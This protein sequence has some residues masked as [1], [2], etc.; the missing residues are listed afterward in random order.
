MLYLLILYNCLKFRLKHKLYDLYVGM[1]SYLKIASL[2]DY[3]NADIFEMT[4]NDDVR[5]EHL[6][7]TNNENMILMV[8][9][10]NVL[11]YKSKR[12]QNNNKLFLLEENSDG[13]Y[14]LKNNGLCLEWISI[15]K[16]FEAKKC[17]ASNE[18]QLFDI[19]KVHGDFN[20]FVSKI[21]NHGTVP[22]NSY[23]ELVLIAE[24]VVPKIELDN[25][26]VIYGI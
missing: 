9:N 26:R 20:E 11:V 16:L 19:E 15:T 21:Y 23:K 13:F 5:G 2:T 17:S 8:N 24:R 18:S 12:G 1:D 7:T 6:V 14:H 25:F 4:T 3:D 22:G 10:D